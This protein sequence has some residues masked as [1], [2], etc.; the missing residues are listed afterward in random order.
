MVGQETGKAGVAGQETGKAGV[1]GQETGKAGVA[2][3]ATGVAGQE[4]LLPC[5]CREE[6]HM[7]SAVLKKDYT[8]IIEIIYYL[9][10]NRIIVSQYNLEKDA[11]ESEPELKWSH[12]LHFLHLLHLL[13]FLHH[14]CHIETQT[15][16]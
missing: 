9:Y 16:I 14:V 7:T 2:G 1:V 3:K 12:F 8:I 4:T 11:K 6:I 15:I 13:H 10:N 5:S